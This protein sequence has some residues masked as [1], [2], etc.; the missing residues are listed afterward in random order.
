[1]RGFSHHPRPVRPVAEITAL[2]GLIL[3]I[4]AAL[5]ALPH[6]VIG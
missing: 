6:G 2:C 1:M 3:A 4:G 5:A